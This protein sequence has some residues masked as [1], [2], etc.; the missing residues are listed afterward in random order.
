MKDN[1]NEPR[2]VDVQDRVGIVDALYRFAAGQDLRDAELFESAFSEQATLDITGPA[3]LLGA[4]LPVLQGR[5]T[6]SGA[7]MAS[8]DRLD[9][10]HTVTNPRIVAYDGESARLSALVEANNLPRGDHGRQ[11]LLK[12]VYTADLSKHDGRWTIDNLLIENIWITGDPAVL[13][14]QPR[15]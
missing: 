5:P 14:P 9:T 13:F 8:T 11:L 1:V 7:L 15:T 3:K 6:I 2:D 4:E 10:S 12:N